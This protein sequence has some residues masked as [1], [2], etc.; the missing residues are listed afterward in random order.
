MFRAH[1]E[2]LQVPCRSAEQM[3]LVNALCR[4]VEVA[5]EQLDGSLVREFEAAPGAVAR[6]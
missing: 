6:T 1:P 4:L 5:D 2:L 3:R